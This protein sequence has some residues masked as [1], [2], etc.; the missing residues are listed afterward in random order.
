[1]RRATKHRGGVVIGVTWRG[2]S[3]RVALEPFQG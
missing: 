1:M 3:L 2:G